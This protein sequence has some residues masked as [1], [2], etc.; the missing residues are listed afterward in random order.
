[1]PALTLKRTRRRKSR[2]P[3]DSL[4]IRLMIRVVITAEKIK[5]TVFMKRYL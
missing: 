4:V 2:R 5:D 1:M 3:D